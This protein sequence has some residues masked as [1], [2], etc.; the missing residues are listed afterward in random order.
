MKQRARLLSGMVA[1]GATA[2]LAVSLTAMAAPAS[3]KVQAIRAGGAQFTTDG[4]TWNTLQVGTTLHAGAT[5]KTDAAGVVDLDLGR[6][7]PALRITPD[8]TL[9]IQTLDLMTGEGETAATTELGLPNGKIHATVRKLG[10][11]SK[12]EIK[13]PVSTCGVRGTDLSA[14]SRGDFVIENGNGYVRYT[15]PGQT[16]PRQF[17]V[18]GGYT[19]DPSLNNNNGGVIETLPSVK[20]EL[21]RAVADLLEFVP[22]G[23]RAQ[24]WAPRPA[25]LTPQREGVAPGQGQDGSW[26]LKPV[27][28][29]TTPVKP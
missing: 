11:S 13:T 16:E 1:Y 21:E 12:Y 7:G 6:N 8:T 18:P 27:E 15:A 3:A 10:A 29:P 14:S 2:A 20:L 25:W 19:F 17:Q 9:Q 23:E 24:I 5:V 26:D 22:V 28:N 4:A